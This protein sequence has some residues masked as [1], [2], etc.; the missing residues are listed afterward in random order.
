[1]DAAL[2]APLA[3]FAAIGGLTAYLAGAVGLRDTRRLRRVGI[4]VQALVKYRSTQA[5]D[6]A[7]AARPLLQFVTADET[8]MEVFSPVP[9]GRSQPLTDGGQVW[10][11]Y[12][13]AD[14]RQVVVRGRERAWLD[15]SF[16]ALGAAVLL[17]ALVLFLLAV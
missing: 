3:V 14:P 5:G 10:I 17:G 4:P 6:L 15:L 1:M 11:S 8:V 16:V 7:G 12:D 2:L 9:A 13:P